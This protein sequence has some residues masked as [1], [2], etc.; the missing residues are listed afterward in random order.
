V[1]TL[2]NVFMFSRAKCLH[3]LQRAPRGGVLVPHS[4]GSLGSG[5]G[6]SL[7]E[8]RGSLPFSNSLSPV[9][10]SNTGSGSMVALTNMA[11]TTNAAPTRKG[12]PGTEDA[13]WG[14]SVSPGTCAGASINST[15]PPPSASA[16]ARTGGAP[17][18]AHC[19]RGKTR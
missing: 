2:F 5:A 15:R 18:P 9:R 17:F 19:E 14:R 11:T 4:E 12:K 16:L 13:W 8:S 3:T 7:G 6:E 10:A 1:L